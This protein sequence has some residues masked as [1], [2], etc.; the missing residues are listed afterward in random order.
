MCCSQTLSFTVSCV[1]LTLFVQINDDDDDDDDD[2][3]VTT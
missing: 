2:D 1:L 3:I